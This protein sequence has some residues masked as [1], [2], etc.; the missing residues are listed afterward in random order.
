MDGFTIQNV[1]IKSRKHF[2]SMKSFSK[3]TIQ[4]VPIKLQNDKR[5]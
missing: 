1:P 3:F 4:N 5:K 2:P